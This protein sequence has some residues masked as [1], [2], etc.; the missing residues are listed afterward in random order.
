MVTP[1]ALLNLGK[2]FLDALLEQETN[3]VVRSALGAQ[4][5]DHL[6]ARCGTSR[7]PSGRVVLPPKRPSGELPATEAPA[8]RGPKDFR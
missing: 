2:A 6:D 3:P 5:A 4:L 8:V 7:T 1:S